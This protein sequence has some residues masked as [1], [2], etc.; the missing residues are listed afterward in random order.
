MLSS[1]YYINTSE[2][3]RDSLC[4]HKDGDLFTCEHMKVSR[5]SSLRCYFTGV[6]II[7]TITFLH[8]SKRIFSKITLQVLISVFSFDH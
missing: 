8:L 7:N 4:I 5:E 3:R 6:Y 1:I 2:K